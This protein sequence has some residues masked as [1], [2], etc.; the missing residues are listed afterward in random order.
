MLLRQLGRVKKSDF[1]ECRRGKGSKGFL[2]F[3]KSDE[4]GKKW[5]QIPKILGIWRKTAIHTA[6]FK[7]LGLIN[8]PLFIH[9]KFLM[10]SA[11]SG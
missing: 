1:M 5:S 8:S 10:F 3:R 4:A 6:G 11:A 9:R 2:P 7:T